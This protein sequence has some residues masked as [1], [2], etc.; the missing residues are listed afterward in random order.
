M[1][2]M[3]YWSDSTILLQGQKKDVKEKEGDKNKDEEDKAANVIATKLKDDDPPRL[4][5]AYVGQV[6]G[7]IRGILINI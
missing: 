1:C 7:Y 3:S 2:S 6:S 4:L 5:L